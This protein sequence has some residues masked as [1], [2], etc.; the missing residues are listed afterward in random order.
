M[1]I[2]GVLI[3]QES[4]FVS[5]APSIYFQSAEAPLLYNPDADG[6]YWG[7]S[8]TTQYPIYEIGCPAD[9]SFTENLQTNEVLCDN[10]G[11]V[12]TVQQRQYVDLQFT[13]RSMFP[14]HVLRHLLSF[15]PVTESSGYQ[16]MGIG[17]ID[18]VFWHVYTPRVYDASAGDYVWIH[19]HRAKFV[20]AWTIN[21]PFGGAWNVTGL[22]LRAFADSTKGDHQRFGM[23][24]RF[25]PSAIP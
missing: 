15:G 16:K 5:D 22:V 25:D 4:T 6:F 14:L 13:V 10:I 21:M 19:L 2:T 18:E 11:L 12:S 1:T 8:G 23:F 3:T 7:L 20:N 24:G 17:A 9:V